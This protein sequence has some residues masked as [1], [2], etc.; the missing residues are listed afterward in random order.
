MRNRSNTVY[1]RT[2]VDYLTIIMI[3]P[4]SSTVATAC[5]VSSAPIDRIPPIYVKIGGRLNL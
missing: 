4:P 2:L 5:P 3:L 1:G